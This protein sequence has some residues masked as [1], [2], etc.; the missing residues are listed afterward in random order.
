MTR[1]FLGEG[2]V[3]LWK[4][5]H[6]ITCII[7]VNIRC[8]HNKLCYHSSSLKVILKTLKPKQNHFL[9]DIFK[10]I[11]LKENASISIK[12]SLKFLSSDPNINIPE[13][14]R[15]MFGAGQ[16]TNHYLKQWWPSFLTHICVTWLQFINK[17]SFDYS[18]KRKYND[19]SKQA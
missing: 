19:M 9:C 15:I 17:R 2:L 16:A 1:Y 10:W 7:I 13:L 4:R 8:C 12:N 18:I 6:Y 14:I 5:V 11:L 3:L